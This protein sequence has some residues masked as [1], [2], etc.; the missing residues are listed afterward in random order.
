MY[1]H[2]MGSLS[3]TDSYWNLLT[4]VDL[5]NYEEQTRM[6]KEGTDRISRECE[7]LYSST[8]VCRAFILH[9][10]SIMH[11]IRSNR[12]RVLTSIQKSSHNIQKRGLMNIV[13]RVANVLFGTCDDKDAERFY[14]QINEFDKFKLST[15]HLLESQ[16]TIVRNTVNDINETMHEAKKLAKVY[17]DLISHEQIMTMQT[18]I[19]LLINL[20]SIEIENLVDI[21]NYAIQ[22]RIHS[23]IMSP[24]TIIEQMNN[25]QGKLPPNAEFPLKLSTD[26]I[27]DLFKIATVTVISVDDTLIFSIEIPITN[28]MRFMVYEVIPLPIHINQDQVVIIE[29]K[30]SYIAVDKTQ[31]NFISFG[32]LELGRCK[33]VEESYVCPNEHPINFDNVLLNCEQTLFNSPSNIPSS[34]NKK[35][36]L[37]KPTVWHRLAGENAWLFVV[38]NETITIPCDNEIQPIRINLN[39]SG[40]INLDSKCKIYTKNTILLPTRKYKSK[41]LVDFYPKIALDVNLS[42]FNNI[43]SISRIQD[44]N[45]RLQYNFKNLAR[46]AE[47]LKFLQGRISTEL[48]RDNDK[49]NDTYTTTVVVISAVILIVIIFVLILSLY[50]KR[51]M[52][53]NKC[54]PKG[55]EISMVLPTIQANTS[56]EIKAE[57]CE[58]KGI[59]AKNPLPEII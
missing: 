43:G 2:A 48:N 41:S 59:Q 45:N 56:T 40:K 4:Y 26:S 19:I 17:T 9:T 57:A 34:C 14:N 10:D 1:Y 51:S 33:V 22:G 12:Q 50:I 18:D 37:S 25:I 54:K 35:V 52:S 20:L 16:T 29:V 13:G 24:K 42:N 53:K 36:L 55:T 7:N 11:Q 15:T 5:R 46:D 28:G 8:S 32:E 27:S 44:T 3:I 58:N 6:I 31:K 30:T 21:V 47:D 49:N 23:S 39:N 38:Q